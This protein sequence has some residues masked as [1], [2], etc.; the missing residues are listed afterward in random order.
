MYHIVILLGTD[1]FSL[2]SDKL[3]TLTKVSLLQKLLLRCFKLINY[4]WNFT[5]GNAA[6]FPFSFVTTKK[7]KVSDT[8]PYSAQV[9]ALRYS[10]GP[11]LI[12]ISD[13]RNML[14]GISYL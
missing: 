5:R 10:E 1:Y 14:Q 12:R 4:C 9:S 8:H 6:K 13:F 11:N 3:L 2:I 7:R